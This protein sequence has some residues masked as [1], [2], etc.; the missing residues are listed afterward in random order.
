TYYHLALN[1]FDTNVAELLVSMITIASLLIVKECI[2]SRCQR[3]KLKMP[4]PI[5]LLVVVVGTLVS[6]TSNLPDNYGVAIVGDIPTGIPAP[7]LEPLNNL[8]YLW[9]IIDAFWIAL[10]SFTISVSLGK[11]LGKLH[12][13][14]INP[15]Q[16][17]LAFGVCNSVGSL[18]STFC[19]G[20][21]MSRSMVQHSMGVNTQL[22]GLLN[23]IL[24][25]VVMLFVG[26]LFRTLPRCILACIVLVALK[27]MFMQYKDLP[28]LWNI[29]KYDFAMW[30]VMYLAVLLLGVDIGLV[31]GVGFSLFTIILRSARPYCCLYGQAD[32]SDIY[33]D[34][35]KYEYVKELDGIKIFHFEASLYYANADHFRRSLFKLTNA[36]PLALKKDRRKFGKRKRRFEERVQKQL[37]KK[38]KDSGKQDDKKPS[39]S[40]SQANL[41]Q[42]SLELQSPQPSHVVPTQEIPTISTG[43]PTVRPF[44]RMDTSYGINIAPVSSTAPAPPANTSEYQEAQPSGP[45]SFLKKAL[46]FRKDRV[47]LDSEFS[48]KVNPVRA[49]D[50]HEGTP[51]TSMDP[52]PVVSGRYLQAIEEDPETGGYEEYHMS[53]DI[54]VFEEEPPN[55][56]ISHIVL[57][58]SAMM[59]TDAVGV[60]VLNQVINDYKNVDVMVLLADCR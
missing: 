21:A 19:C 1:L 46:H 36:N 16:E 4:V 8:R 42:T 13:Y 56:D 48:V 12:D 20:G 33:R 34:K 60:K 40:D 59:Y 22:S 9:L 17:L 57:D 29:S 53:D 18:F 6:F 43:R 27:G 44:R 37:R 55:F 24:T 47:R 5:E 49:Q 58:C 7:T 54:P 31:T 50:Y 28:K 3:T 11:L 14:E 25:L 2:N 10:I 32:D 51:Q 30:I 39:G 26:P 38:E 52:R 23:S 41:S 45:L 15:D 35:T